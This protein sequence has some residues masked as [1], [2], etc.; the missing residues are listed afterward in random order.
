LSDLQDRNIIKGNIDTTK[1]TLERNQTK[2]KL[3]NLFTPYGESETT[4]KTHPQFGIDP[5]TLSEMY[6]DQPFGIPR[7]LSSCF[8]YLEKRMFY[9]CCLFVYLVVCC[10]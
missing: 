6:P 8:A 3:A 4:K 5:T 2:L 9:Y 10:A 7:V 1:T